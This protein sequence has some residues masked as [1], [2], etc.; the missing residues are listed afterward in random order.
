M[1]RCGVCSN[2]RSVIYDKVEIDCPVCEEAVIIEEHWRDLH[3][4]TKDRRKKTV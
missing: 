3:V 2:T 4:D 1:I